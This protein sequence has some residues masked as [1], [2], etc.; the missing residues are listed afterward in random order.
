ME[1]PDVLCLYINVICLQMTHKIVT[2][3]NGAL[4]VTN[5]VVGV[6]YQ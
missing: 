1:V 3:L 5:R 6:S 4:V 2:K